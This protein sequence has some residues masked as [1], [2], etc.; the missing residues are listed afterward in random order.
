MYKFVKEKKNEILHICIY[1]LINM[2]PSTL[3]EILL[4]T[5]GTLIC[6]MVYIGGAKG[7]QGQREIS[8]KQHPSHAGWSRYAVDGLDRIQRW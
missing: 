8:T 3:L 2:E 4:I 1:V 7:D 6:N 5:M